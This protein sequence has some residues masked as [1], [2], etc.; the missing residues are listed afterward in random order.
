MPEIVVNGRFLSRSITGVERYGREILSFIESKCRV[1]ET[2]VNGLAG[3]M[4]EQFILPTRL[5]SVSFLWSPAN[6]GPWMVRDQALTIHDL[7]PLEHPEYFTKSFSLW[8][9]LFLPPLAKKVRVVFTPSSYIQRKVIERFGIDNVIVTPNGVDTQRFRP[10]AQQAPGEL[11]RQFLLF[12]GSLQPRKNLQVLLDAW[13]QVRDEYQDLW[14]V[15]AGDRGPVFGRIKITSSERVIYLGYVAEHELPGLYARARWLVLPSLEEGFGL[16]ALE[17]MACGTPVIV[18]DGGALPEIV[19]NA[20]VLFKLSEPGSLLHA[21]RSC[22]DNDDLRSSLITS[23]FERITH[24]SWQYSAE[25]I[26]KTLNEA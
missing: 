11:P 14:L 12:I 13:K 19:G 16:P 4:W 18:S 20:A 21:L 17:S 5:P 1:E 2:R 26:W 10:D 22:L 8:Y 3:H 23:G 24:F 9:R 6:T 15:I 7:S 25:L